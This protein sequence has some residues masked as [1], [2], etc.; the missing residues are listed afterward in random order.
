M[1][2]VQFRIPHSAIRISFAVLTICSISAV[3]MRIGPTRI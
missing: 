1:G 3:E 2:G